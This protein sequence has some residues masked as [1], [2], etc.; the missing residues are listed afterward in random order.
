MSFNVGI[1]EAVSV[2]VE[3]VGAELYRWEAG[4][5]KGIMAIGDGCRR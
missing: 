2:V 5:D 3:A 1:G 4:S